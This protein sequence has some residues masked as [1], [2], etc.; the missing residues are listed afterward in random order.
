MESAIAEMYSF[1]GFPSFSGDNI[2]GLVRYDLIL[3]KA[4]WCSSFH[5]NSL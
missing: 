5:M 4:C 1:K 2:G 3:S